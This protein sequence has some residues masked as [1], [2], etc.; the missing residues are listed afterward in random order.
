MTNEKITECL[1]SILTCLQTINEQDDRNLDFF[2]EIQEKHNR[3]AK[4]T[5]DLLK[6]LQWLT[7]HVDKHFQLLYNKINRLEQELNEFRTIGRIDSP[8][9]SIRSGN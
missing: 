8:E 9:T 3:L 4:V 7:T 2:R 1:E 6:D 5:F